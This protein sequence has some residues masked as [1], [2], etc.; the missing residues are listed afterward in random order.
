M[1]DKNSST[2]Y[3]GSNNGMIYKKREG[4]ITSTEEIVE[5]PREY[6]LDQNYP[7]PFNPATTI[8]FGVRESGSYRLV[9]YNI[10]GEQV[11][12]LVNGE[13]SAGY[14]KVNF[15]ASRLASGI[16]LYKLA[17]D[18]VNITKKMILMK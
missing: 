6:K 17:G 18:K 13:L 14:H 15:D 4:G 1:V 11:A 16:Y 9:I 7:N 10:I 5:T 12:E 3:A 8:E 2:L